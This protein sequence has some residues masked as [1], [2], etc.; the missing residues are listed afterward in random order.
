MQDIG[1]AAAASGVSAKMIRHCEEAGLR[2]AA[3]R[4]DSGRRHYG[5]SD[6]QTLHVVRHACRQGVCIPEIPKRVG[7]WPDRSRPSRE[8]KAPTQTHH[9]ERQA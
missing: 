8:V 3:R 2:P 6:A 9:K 4:T 5:G 1:Q 7:L